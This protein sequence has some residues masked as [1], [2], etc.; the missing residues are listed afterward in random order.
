MIR[1]EKKEFEHRGFPCA[2][3][4][5]EYANLNRLKNE[6]LL[7]KGDKG[8]WLWLCIGL[9][10]LNEKQAKQLG[11]KILDEFLDASISEKHETHPE[12]TKNLFENNTQINHFLHFTMNRFRYPLFK[13][14]HQLDEELC[15]KYADKLI[16]SIEMNAL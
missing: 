10:E 7:L 12:L 6:D 14:N 15:K 9:T 3:M 2:I 13:E 16:D 8:Q 1:L 5:M 4:K 11:Y